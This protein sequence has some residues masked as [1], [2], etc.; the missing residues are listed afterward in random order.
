MEEKELEEIS[1]GAAVYLQGFALA[2]C[3]LIGAVIIGL[4]DFRHLDFDAA[5]FQFI[6]LGV[7]AL[8]AMLPLLYSDVYVS[9]SDI[10]IKKITGTK[11]RSIL[12]YKEVGSTVFFNA[13]YIKFADNTRFYFAL[14]SIDRQKDIFGSCVL[15]ALS[16]KLE[17]RKRSVVEN[18]KT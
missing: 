18:G 9:E 13:Y 12:E 10:I 14:G 6:I 7:L 2:I 3:T 15:K 16:S 17:E 1:T 4:I 11:R 8:F 5:C